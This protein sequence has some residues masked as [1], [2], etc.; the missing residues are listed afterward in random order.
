MHFPFFVSKKYIAHKGDKKFISLISMITIIGIS[1]GVAIL[2]ITLSI[3][4]GFE[5]TITEKVINFNSHIKITSFGN[6]NLDESDE[7]VFKIKNLLGENFKDI[8]PFLSKL[9]IIKSKTSS[10]GITLLGIKTDSCNIDFDQILIKG[11]I[12]EFENK[13]SPK[14]ILGAKLAEKLFIK[15]G[16]SVTIFSLSNDKIPSQEN[17]PG[18]LQFI[19]S[20]IYQSGMKEYDDVYAYVDINVLRKE[21]NLGEVIS[22]YNIQIKDVSAADSLSMY[23]QEE[24]SYP[25]YVRSIFSLHRNIFTWLDLQKKPIPIILGLI[26]IVAIFNIVGTILINVLEKTKEIGILKSL[27]STKR[28]IISIFTL[29]GAFLGFVGIVIGNVLAILL[30]SLQMRYEIISIPESVYYL[31]KV[32]ID[33]SLFN[34]MLISGLAFVL[35]LAASFIPSFI[36]AQVKPVSAMKFD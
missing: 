14:I 24:L 13:L 1:L 27:G 11:N 19:V 9:A 7:N 23:L 21:L 2:I 25:H 35:C 3:L 32:P 33:I 31:S 29:Q 34:Y 6:R 20:G 17:P 30:S 22:G 28:Q 16:D 36:A 5:K 15:L 18:I 12:Q 10:E 4:D 8:S 26:I